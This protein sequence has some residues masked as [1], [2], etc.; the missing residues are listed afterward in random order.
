MH[1][2]AMP[3]SRSPPARELFP[4]TAP[5]SASAWSRDHAD[6]GAVY[7]APSAAARRLVLQRVADARATTLGLTVVAPGRLLPLLESR[8]GLPAPRTL[9]PALERILV[10][11][12]ARAAR[13]PLFD[14]VQ[15]DAPAGAVR[16]VTT[17][18]R[19]LRNNRVSPDA[20]R[21]AGGD[22]RAADAYARFE[23]QR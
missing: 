1:T 2:A 15:H 3:L 13:V 16:A 5:A 9:S 12:A 10:S 4:H 19:T 8:A 17:L 11:K 22:P 21:A 7:V 14:D 6:A 20:F 23:T 18:I